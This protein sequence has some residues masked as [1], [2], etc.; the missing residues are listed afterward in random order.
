MDT[1]EFNK[2]STILIYGYGKVGKEL[3]AKLIKNGYKVAAFIDKN[4]EN[5]EII[6]D[7]RVIL[8]EELTRELLK[9]IIVLTFQN[10]LEHERVAKTL[11]EKGADKI[12]YLN[13]K[14]SEKY[15]KCFEI[16]NHLVYG[17]T[18][19]DFEFPYTKLKLNNSDSFYYH[20][21]G[22]SITVEVPSII[23]FSAIEDHRIGLAKYMLEEKNI[24]ALNEYNAVYELIQKGKTGSIEDF[25]RYCD[26]LCGTGRTLETFLQDRVL[27]FDMMLEEYEQQGIAF[28][29]NS[30]SAAKW[31]PKGYFN[32]IDGH[33]RAIFLINNL[34]HAIPIR[35]SNDDYDKWCNPEY[36]Q[37]CKEYIEKH[38]IKKTYTP[39]INP[40][41]FNMESVIENRGR[42]T[43]SSLYKYFG[44][45]DVTKYSVL[46]VYS[47]LSY[48]AQVF[49]RMGVL[50]IVSLENRKLLFN[51]AI[52]LNNLHY[53]TNI[54]MRNND[55]LEMDENELFDIV[56]LANDIYL[57]F[58]KK[59]GVLLLEKIDALSSQYF[60]WRSCV[61]IDNEKK[62]ILEN[63]NFNKYHFLNFE[64]IEGKLVEIGIYEK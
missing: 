13:R 32:L 60:I 61:D 8:P 18:V 50:K 29:R 30:P 27:L 25:K 24:V 48:Y 43:S 22:E 19:T 21:A 1:F 35:I 56:I 20:Q 33:H 44:R 64:V 15:E 51:L 42:R 53:T 7:H 17:E 37:I 5:T 45:E 41:F 16:W 26:I 36:V 28:F 47:N 39:I 46:D 2:N 23:V 49:T 12:I 14:N 4:A 55:L 31:N 9:C 40:A 59:N 3:Y 63:S 62:Y 52:L 58:T 6:G 57:D 38:H 54:E 11:Y 34:N 10:I